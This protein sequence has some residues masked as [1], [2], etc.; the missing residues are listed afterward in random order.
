[1]RSRTARGTTAR[2]VAA[3]CL[4]AL[5]ASGCASGTDSAAEAGDP[6]SG[7][8]GA[9]P[10]DAAAEAPTDAATDRPEQDPSASSTPVATETSAEPSNP[11][12]VDP[13]YA[14]APPGPRT[15]PVTVADVLVTSE[16]TLDPALVERL[17]SLDGVTSSDLVSMSNVSVE[18]KVYNVAAVDPGSYRTFTEAGSAD[19]Q[20]QWDRVAAGEVAVADR[21]ERRLPMDDDGFVDLGGGAAD[22]TDLLH[23]G[24]FAPQIEQV[25]LVVNRLRGEE[26]G[27]VADN[28]LLIHTGE[29][30][31]EA[32]KGPIE[33][34]VGDGVSVQNLDAVARFG[35]D[36]DAFQNAVF[37]GDFAD[38][39]GVFRYTPIGGGRIAPE[40]S[41]VAEHITTGVVPILG[42]VTCNVAIFPQLEAALAEV[43]RSGLADKINPDEYAGCYYPRFIAGSTELSNHSFG[44]AFDLN[45]PGNQRGTVGEIDRGVVA[46]FKRWGFAW[47][48]D[49]NYTDPMHFEL[50]QIVRPG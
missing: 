45:V 14:V 26:L 11:P 30:S 37:Y 38:A 6:A 2:A 3:G 18:N 44:L 31:P 19:L 10:S 41:W 34:L 35:L 42:S 22:S 4:L 29:T 8:V 36:P 43:Q 32:L 28:A 25:D 27:M 7:G 16:D 15:G 20:A 5:L 39:V 13:A 47:G 21:L 24:A 23:V 1:M 48:G 33:R 49:W 46:I 12:A 9:A 40:P 50:D 17:T